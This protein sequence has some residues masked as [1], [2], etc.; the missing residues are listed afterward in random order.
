M[1]SIVAYI[2][3][4]EGM[5]TAPT[6]FLLAEARRVAD[7][8]GATVYALLALGPLDHSKIDELAEQVSAGGA[9]RVLCSTH[10]R[11]AGPPL[12]ATHGGI[13]GQVAEHLRP[14]LFL[15][16]AGG[17]GVELG[18]SLAVRTGAAYVPNAHL[19]LRSERSDVAPASQ[20]V[21]LTRWRA[22]GDGRRRIDVGD[23]ERPVVAVLASGRVSR[24]RGQPSPEVETIPCPEP[25]FP[26]LR[27][28]EFE[29]L[30]DSAVEECSAL[31]CTAVPA[32]AAA[33]A[34]LKSALPAGAALLTTPSQDVAALQAA[35]PS[36][37][38]LLSPGENTI[39]LP[40][41]VP[42]GS[43]S[44]VDFAEGAKGTARAPEDALFALADALGRARARREGGA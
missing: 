5:V 3:V 41:P 13:L 27:L 10:E 25:R 2:D 29:A 31:V 36:H 14:V 38:F 17:V 20:R 33:L 26:E 15:F 42:G 19:E 16:P 18:P 8:A 9:D 44:L 6:R 21:V 32:D 35:R 7:F 12:D 37:V 1:A 40:P 43:V 24:P 30:P 4:R 22:A 23:L 28:L 11:L 34:S 39:A